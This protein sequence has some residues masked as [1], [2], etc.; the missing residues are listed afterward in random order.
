MALA[1]SSIDASRSRPC[2]SGNRIERV[3]L[4]YSAFSN[5]LAL[6]GGTGRPE[7]SRIFPGGSG[8][9]A[10]GWNNSP[11]VGMPTLPHAGIARYTQEL[12]DRQEL[13]YLPWAYGDL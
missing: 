1:T 7:P 9:G 5:K 4:A 11:I 12:G 2:S 6:D 8:G 13:T 3:A 10:V